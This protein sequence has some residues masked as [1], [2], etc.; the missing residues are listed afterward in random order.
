MLTNTTIELRSPKPSMMMRVIK[1]LMSKRKPVFPHTSS[2]FREYMAAREL[3]RDAPM[4]A[5]LASDQMG[6]VFKATIADA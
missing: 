1:W 5:K 6:G 3:P 2:E 4:P